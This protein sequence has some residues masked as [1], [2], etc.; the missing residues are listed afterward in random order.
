MTVWLLRTGMG[1]DGYG[2]LRQHRWFDGFD[3]AA[4]R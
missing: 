4:L 1:V 2:K 3:W